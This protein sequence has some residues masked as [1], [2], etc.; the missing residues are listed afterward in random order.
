[1]P[2]FYEVFEK[3]L[4]VF[5]LSTYIFHDRRTVFYRLKPT[6]LGNIFFNYV[7][8]FF[9]HFSARNSIFDLKLFWPKNI[10]KNVAKTY[11]LQTMPR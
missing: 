4:Y 1:M 3:C 7:N 6:F 11:K 10:F 9:P 5:T 8:P 2:R